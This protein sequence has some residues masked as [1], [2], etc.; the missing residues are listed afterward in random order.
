MYVSLFDLKDLCWWGWVFECISISFPCPFVEG[1]VCTLALFS[2]CNLC[3]LAPSVP[4]ASQR[5][6]TSL[7]DYRLVQFTCM[8]TWSMVAC[9][10]RF[11]CLEMP[12]NTVGHTGTSLSIALT[13]RS[14]W[15]RFCCEPVVFRSELLL[16][17]PLFEPVLLLN[18]Q[19]AERSN[20]R[21]S[22]FREQT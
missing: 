15:L 21:E 22:S 11:C 19:G 2:A 6:I 13:S 18:L 1:L 9:S 20:S 5:T 17:L 7:E 12:L 16:V 3:W 8:V 4:D 10:M 14:P